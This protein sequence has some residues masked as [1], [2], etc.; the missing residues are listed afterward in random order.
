MTSFEAV[1]V[2][3]GVLPLIVSALENYERMIGPNRTFRKYSKALQTF[4]TELNVQ[5]NIFENECIFI[6]DRFVDGHELRDMLQDP[7]HSLRNIVGGDPNLDLT[8]SNTI[9][10][11]YGQLCD[12]LQLIK[13][14]L[15]EIYEDTRSHSDGLS[16]PP[17]REVCTM[18]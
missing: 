6:L 11:S 16:R 4:N 9:G 1:G 18:P 8:V 3:L 7:C 10:A 12:I 14:S 15:D 17:R 5:R 2:V 13:T